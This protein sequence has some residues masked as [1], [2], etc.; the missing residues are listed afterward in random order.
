MLTSVWSVKTYLPDLAD[1]DFLLENAHGQF[2]TVEPARMVSDHTAVTPP[3]L[4][5]HIQGN[6]ISNAVRL[7]GGRLILSHPK[8]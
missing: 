2:Q 3:A 4:E 5:K 7:Q 6:T 8:G 1:E